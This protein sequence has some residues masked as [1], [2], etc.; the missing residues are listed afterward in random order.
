[1]F[2]GVF[3]NPEEIF[4]HF[5][6]LSGCSIAEPQGS[7]VDSCEKCRYDVNTCIWRCYCNDGGGQSD[8]SSFDMDSCESAEIV[9]CENSNG[10]MQC[11]CNLCNSYIIYGSILIFLYFLTLLIEAYISEKIWGSYGATRFL[12]L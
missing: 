8:E 5:L 7:Y 1:M 9:R 11:D 3:N 4:L 2:Q 10:K 12:D 6:F